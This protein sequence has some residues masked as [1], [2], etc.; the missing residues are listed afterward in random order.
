M[1]AKGNSGN[2]GNGKKDTRD[3]AS[4]RINN[5]R[6]LHEYHIDARLEC[7]IVLRGSE[8]KSLRA[9]KAQLQDAFARVEKGELILHDAHID[10]YEKAVGFGHIPKTERK[11]LAHRR[12]IK[13][14]EDATRERGTTLIPL[15]IY[16]K[17]GRAK[18]EIAVARG[19]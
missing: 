7:G 13:K 12:E 14:L 16:F 3:S 19:K 17:N 4:P 10:P 5:R 15:A 1:T 11:L 8:V 2:S 9:G 6:A 18:V